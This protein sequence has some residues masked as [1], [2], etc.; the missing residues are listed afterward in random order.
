M[1]HNQYAPK[2]EPHDPNKHYNQHLKDANDKF[3][4]H[5]DASM[6]SVG[7][8]VAEVVKFLCVAIIGLSYVM[9]EVIFVKQPGKRF[10]K[11][12]FAP[13]GYSM[14]GRAQIFHPFVKIILFLIVFA[15]F[16]LIVTPLLGGLGIFITLPLVMILQGC[17]FVS[18][19]N[20]IGHS[21]SLANFFGKELSPLF[22]YMNG[23]TKSDSTQLTIGLMALGIWSLVAS[24]F[25]FYR[26]SDAEARDVDHPGYLNIRVVS[27]V[28]VIV[29]LSF[30]FNLYV[31]CTAALVC[32]ITFSVHRFNH[33][34]SREADAIDRSNAPAA[35]ESAAKD[36]QLLEERKLK[37]GSI[38]SS[39]RIAT[40]TPSRFA[41]STPSD[42]LFDQSSNPLPVKKVSPVAA[43]LEVDD[44]FKSR[45]EQLLARAGDPTIS[46]DL[47][48][49]ALDNLDDAAR[50]TIAAHKETL[51][52]DKDE[53][54]GMG[55]K[56]G[57]SARILSELSSRGVNTNLL[58]VET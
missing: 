27:S 33:H 40:A 29:V 17:G 19:A 56:A 6:R 52:G 42:P 58:G 20:A 41:I 3:T 34:I 39:V 11:T 30:V 23:I 57:S 53:S 35:A 50:E 36:L 28:W 12:V 32:A 18:L 4:Q 15:L 47:R 24:V 8:I 5:S 16:Y 13:F 45:T 1:S 38:G 2:F 51:D 55:P 7:A 9:L 44:D 25:S 22:F 54:G 37:E 46:P 10:L 14:T 43:L 49:E 31:F 21:A 26:M 48:K